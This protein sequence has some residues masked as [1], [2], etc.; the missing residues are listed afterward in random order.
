MSMYRNRKL[1]YLISILLVIGL[2]VCRPKPSSGP[3]A[4]LAFVSERDGNQEIYLIQPDGSALERLTDHPAIDADPAFSPDGRQI[5]FRSR[6]DDTSDIFVM[7]ADGSRP[8]NV[9]QNP[10]AD[11]WP[12]W[13]PVSP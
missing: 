1:I 13:S 3:V 6:R 8:R 10:A 2:P 5:A 11:Y 4:G 12:N 7:G 9:T